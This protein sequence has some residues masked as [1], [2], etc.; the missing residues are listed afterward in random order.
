MLLRETSAWRHENTILHEEF[1]DHLM[2][3]AQV[4]AENTSLKDQ[5]AVSNHE[6]ARVAARRAIRGGVFPL[7]RL[8]AGGTVVVVG[9]AAAVVFSS[10]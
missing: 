4:L 3:S 9:S 1:A 6:Y 2:S 5:I 10:V 8:G 7:S